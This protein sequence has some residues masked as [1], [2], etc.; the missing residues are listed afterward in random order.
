MSS[1]HFS[2]E[3]SKYFWEI[4]QKLITI[5][6]HVN[7]NDIEGNWFVAWTNPLKI[8]VLALKIIYDLEHV[9]NNLE[10]FT[11]ETKRLL[12]K[13]SI[14]FLEEVNSINKIALLL[15]EKWYNGRSVIEIIASY[16]LYDILNSSKVDI[17]VNN[18][19]KGIYEWDFFLSWS[20][21]YLLYQ[22]LLSIR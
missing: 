22:N 12:N 3:N 21:T 17:V 8:W 11:I 4:I 6:P 2:Y 1:Q 5:N 10:F 16:S 15:Q 9:H 18:Y 19:W 20:S 7:L 13:Y 14:V